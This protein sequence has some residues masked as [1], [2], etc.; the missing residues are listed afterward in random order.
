MLF[1]CVQNTFRD[2]LDTR[3]MTVFSVLTEFVTSALFLEYYAAYSGN[4]LLTFWDKL[5]V[6]PPRLRKWS[7]GSSWISGPL[8][9]PTVCPETS[10][11]NYHNTLRNMSGERS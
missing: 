6:R 11:R 2:W 9:E 7:R 8:M 5:P 1:Y 4:S 3:Y 10:V